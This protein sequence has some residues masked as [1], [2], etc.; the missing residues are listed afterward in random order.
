MKMKKVL[1][2]ICDFTDR[3]YFSQIKEIYFSL[4]FLL[5]FLC[6]AGVLPCNYSELIVACTCGCWHCKGKL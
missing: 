3:F 4:L 1:Q 5:F 6:C 2:N